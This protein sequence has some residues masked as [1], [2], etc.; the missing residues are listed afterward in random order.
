MMFPYDQLQQIGYTHPL[1]PTLTHLP[2]GLIMGA[3]LFFLVS[4]F[5][6]KSTLR[7]TAVHC[8][9]LAVIALP[10]VAGL[11]V[12]DWQYFYG[13]SWLFPI[14]MKIGLAAILFVFLI[15]AIYSGLT[16]ESPR[17]GTGLW[18]LICV[19]LVIGL[20]FFGGELVYGPSQTKAA[21]E[22]DTVLADKGSGLFRKN[23]AMCHFTDKSE[24]KVGPGLKGIFDKENLPVSGQEVT[25]TNVRK[26]ILTPYEN[27]PPFEDKLTEKE[28]D[29][30]LAYLKTL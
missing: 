23:C 12:M 2:V 25:K 14:K 30:I 11:G 1:H 4:F 13:G 20:G 22:K 8:I 19:V 3:F 6:K 18:Y 5:S 7:Q 26:Q 27:M 10:V 21:P 9:V 15:V 24:R 28:I 16:K 17:T 29:A